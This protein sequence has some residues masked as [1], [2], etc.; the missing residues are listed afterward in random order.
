MFF[1]RL[2][3]FLTLIV[4]SGVGSNLAAETRNITLVGT[5]SGLVTG[6][7]LVL[8]NNGK[9]LPAIKANGKFN[10]EV[11]VDS[12]Y[13]ITIQTQPANL[14]CIVQDGSGAASKSKPILVTCPMAFHN[15]LIWNRCTHGQTWNAAAGNCTGS[16]K[17][18]SFGAVQVRFC[19]KND[20]TC[21]EGTDGGHLASG[22]A[23]DA[24][25]RL[26]SGNAGFGI[27]TWRLPLKAE[28]AGLVVCTDNTPVPLN[29][30]GKDP[31]KCGYKAGKYVTT[32]WKSP[33]LNNELFPNTMSLEYWSASPHTSKSSAWYTAFQNGWTHMASKANRS[34]VRCV[35]DP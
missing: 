8:A 3:S 25:N 26:N 20:N 19:D 31:Y 35:A 16:G 18:N 6:A 12:Q 14:R 21:N 34:Y 5:V 32:G 7:S 4:L 27:R 1:K 2:F 22:D 28:L 33:A 9:E 29:D 11:P 30:Y 23:F 13:T 15:S 24:C 17:A 10:L